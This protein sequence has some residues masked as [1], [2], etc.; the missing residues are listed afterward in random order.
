[1]LIIPHGNNNRS[2]ILKCFHLSDTIIL[3]LLLLL[4]HVNLTLEI[5][6]DFFLQNLLLLLYA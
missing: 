2:D 4:I 5:R 6:L 3:Q 1:M